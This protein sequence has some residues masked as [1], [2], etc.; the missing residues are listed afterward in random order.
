MST[1]PPSAMI[2]PS[3]RGGI[4]VRRATTAPMSRAAAPNAPQKKADPTA[5]LYRE[6]WDAPITQTG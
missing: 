3:T 1:P 5:G 4:G 2:S 6:G